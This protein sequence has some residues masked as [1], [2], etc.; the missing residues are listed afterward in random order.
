MSNYMPASQPLFVW[1]FADG[2]IVT[3][4]DLSWLEFDCYGRV[5][6][7][8]CLFIFIHTWCVWEQWV[9]SQ[10]CTSTQ[11]RLSHH[12][13]L[14]LSSYLMVHHL[15]KHMC[16]ILCYQHTWLINLSQQTW[17]SEDQTCNH[18]TRSG[19]LTTRPRQI[20]HISQSM[21]FYQLSHI[22]A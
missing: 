19:G 4:W 16:L 6:I 20:P 3:R 1:R 10:D 9:F 14:I 21:R 22:Y 5:T 11:P 15:V 13:L 8:V 18:S 12:S 7:F 2:P 17:E